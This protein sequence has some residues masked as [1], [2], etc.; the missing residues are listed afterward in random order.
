MNRKSYSNA[1]PAIV[2]LVALALAGC[3]DYNPTDTPAG[4]GKEITVAFAEPNYTFNYEDGVELSPV[5]TY[6]N[7]ADTA[8][9]VFAYEWIRKGGDFGSDKLLSAE[10]TL[11]LP[12]DSLD[13]G[14]QQLLLIVTDRRYGAKYSAQVQIEVILK[15]SVGVFVLSKDGTGDSRLSVFA[16]DGEGAFSPDP[17]DLGNIGSDPAGLVYHR[18]RESPQSSQV[19]YLQATQRGAPGTIDICLRTMS[20]EPRSSLDE[21]FGG[22]VP[23]DV[24][25]TYHG[26]HFVITRTQSGDLYRR[27]ESVASR[28]KVPYANSYFPAPVPVEGG[29]RITHWANTSSMNE[30]TGL[31]TLLMYDA[32]NARFLA[33]SN[34]AVS[35]SASGTGTISVV[36]NYTLAEN[37]SANTSRGAPDLK[38]YKPGDLSPTGN[39]EFPAL[40]NLRD[41]EMTGFTFYYLDIYDTYMWDV[42]SA[43]A[44][45]I[46]KRKSDGKRFIL[47]FAHEGNYNRRSMSA[48]LLDFVSAEQTGAAAFGDEMILAG[49][50]DPTLGSYP[51]VFFTDAT[52]T[53]VY[54]YDCT[55]HQQRLV[56]ASASPITAL[57][58]PEPGGSFSKQPPVAHA[59]FNKLLIG[60][61]NGDIVCMGLPDVASGEFVELHKYSTGKEIVDFAFVP[62]VASASSN[63]A[64]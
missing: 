32:L 39:L 7:A 11:R 56:Y 51:Y 48:S 27:N 31:Y 6:A 61:R 28:Y 46:L 41:Y 10:R 40:D 19:A 37:G 18:M 50:C 30:N 60:A 54:R 15:N 42:M 43:K 3:T 2:A 57:Y 64:K 45:A 8:L 38:G 4:T 14:K 23:P 29:A 58:V 24:A 20:R 55:R 25:S 49:W 17:L 35:Y 53:R 13:M 9:D 26:D 12:A 16:I 22:A 33:M 5:V 52:R 62:N 1:V 21:Q 47:T 59:Y 36:N 34:H 44:V 63:L